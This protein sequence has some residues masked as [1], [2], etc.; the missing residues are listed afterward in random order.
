[1]NSILTWYV[2]SVPSPA[3]GL[4]TPNQS[5]ATLPLYEMESSP[6]LASDS[7][8]PV[9]PFPAELSLHRRIK[10]QNCC[11]LKLTK[12]SMKDAGLSNKEENEADNP[13]DGDADSALEEKPSDWDPFQDG[14]EI[15]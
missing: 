15:C 2:Q 3:H 13:T 4:N 10:Y 9:T 11:L 7:L 5:S 6:F 12:E 1:M 14:D 8:N